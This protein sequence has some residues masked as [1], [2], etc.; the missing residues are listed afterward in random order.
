MAI[1]DG[2]SDQ[3]ETSAD[4]SPLGYPELGL[5]LNNQKYALY[6]LFE[7]AY[8]QH[9]DVVLPNMASFDATNGTHQKIEFSKIY[10][11]EKLKNF[12]EAFGVTIL[13]QPPIETENG[14]HSFIAGTSTLGWRA[15]KGAGGLDEFT[16][17]F[18][19]NL[20]P[21][22]TQ[23]DVF[24]K[25]T[26]AVYAQSKI[27][28]VSQLRIEKDWLDVAKVY[29]EHYPEKRNDYALTF[30][31]IM[32][33]TTQSLDVVG[34]QIYVVCDEANL[35]VPKEEI[36]ATTLKK[37]GV[38]LVWKSDFLSAEELAGLSLLELSILDFEMAVRAPT[39]IGTS[40]S[41]FSNLACFEAFCRT[42]KPTTEHYVY[43]CPGEGLLRRYDFGVGGSVEAISDKF[44]YRIPLTPD[45]L[46]DC[47]WPA[48]LT[49]HF[50]FKGD[51]VSETN[52]VPGTR[53]GHLVCG[54]PGS[55]TTTIQGF[56][57]DCLEENLFEVEYRARLGDGSWSDW[58]P[59]GSYVGSRGE[60]REIFG[61]SVR[62]KGKLALSYEAVCIGSFAGR[63]GLIQTK[64]EAGCFSEGG[65]PLEAMQI[66]F[67]TIIPNWP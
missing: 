46:E 48:K 51:F 32:L 63:E 16:C 43:N 13:D 4:N 50:S 1:L 47:L 39:F 60:H 35:P 41:T 52:A 21:H 67:R 9:R 31:D 24:K 55:K 25:L 23:T 54:V 28:V 44:N 59:N 34:R 65:E 45:S 26:K 8:L 2:D 36:R 58:A 19:R 12:A 15:L 37:F 61:F 57:L 53:R 11:V 29:G 17:Q 10:S 38:F 30:Y 49:A 22:V 20:E 40:I 33:K 56:S 6:A 42:G 18:F 5:G 27:S 64:G 14:W 62:L 66:V 7:K 3:F